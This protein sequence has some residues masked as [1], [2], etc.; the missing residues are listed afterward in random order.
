MNITYVTCLNIEV[1]RKY[2]HVHENNFVCFFFFYIYQLQRRLAQNREAARK[3]RLKKKAYVQE[4]ESGRLKLAKLEHE[5][6][7]ARKQVNKREISDQP[8]PVTKSCCYAFWS[9]K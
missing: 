4:L 7:K 8:I 1:A 9:Q 6:E 5:I 3:S 2:I